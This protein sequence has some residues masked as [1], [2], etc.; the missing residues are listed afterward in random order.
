[1]LRWQVAKDYIAIHSM[2]LEIPIIAITRCLS[3]HLVELKE[4]PLLAGSALLK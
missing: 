2:E 1:M 3:E 4:P